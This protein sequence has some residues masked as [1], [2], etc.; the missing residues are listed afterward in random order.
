MTK[1]EGLVDTVDESLV[2]SLL[3]ISEP[4]TKA[5][6]LDAKALKKKDVMKKDQLYLQKGAGGKGAQQQQQQFKGKSGAT[7]AAAS[8]KMT[9][10]LVIDTKDQQMTSMEEDEEGEGGQEEIEPELKMLGEYAQSIQETVAPTV[11]SLNNLFLLN[12]RLERSNDEDYVSTMSS[13]IAQHIADHN[14]IH[15]FDLNSVLINNSVEGVLASAKDIISNL[16]RSVQEAKRDGHLSPEVEQ[17]FRVYAPGLMTPMSEGVDKVQHHVTLEEDQDVSHTKHSDIPVMNTDTIA[18]NLNSLS[19]FVDKG[20]SPL[21]FEKFK[22]LRLKQL[23]EE[24]KLTAEIIEAYGQFLPLRTLLDKMKREVVYRYGRDKSTIESHIQ[25]AIHNHTVGGLAAENMKRQ[26]ASESAEPEKDFGKNAFSINGPVAVGTNTEIMRKIVPEVQQ[27]ISEQIVNEQYVVQLNH[28]MTAREV[29]SQKATNIYNLTNDTIEA[30]R[31]ASRTIGDVKDE[32]V[33]IFELPR[34]IRELVDKEDAEQQRSKWMN[35]GIP[36]DGIDREHFLTHDTFESH[37]KLE[38]NL[39]TLNNSSVNIVT[40]N[41]QSQAQQL[42]EED[43][44]MSFLSHSEGLEEFDK[45]LLDSH[46]A[47]RKERFKKRLEEYEEYV[48]GPEVPMPF[49]KDVEAVSTVGKSGRYRIIAPIERYMDE[50]IDSVPPSLARER[51]INNVRAISTNPTMTIKE[52]QAVIRGLRD[53]Y[54]SNGLHLQQLTPENM[55]VKV[56]AG[57]RTHMH[58]NRV[59]PRDASAQRYMMNKEALL[60]AYKEMKQKNLQAGGEQ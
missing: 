24:G 10:G 60:N 17:L 42:T 12:Q 38:S 43:N 39:T 22:E 2:D 35:H 28:F 52:K 44:E 5:V 9:S 49:I 14:T 3:E 11:Q 18:Q 37:D 57:K 51:L 56:Y 54:V 23:K 48:I 8:K 41:L 32:G 25:S 59:N 33:N 40:K 13:A 30:K 6:K 50:Y 15:Q 19:Q 36:E 53:A 29:R 21:F 26:L 45:S 58:P 4:T 47:V 1:V 31:R 27:A 55:P 20:I 34:M 7:S 16:S 46:I